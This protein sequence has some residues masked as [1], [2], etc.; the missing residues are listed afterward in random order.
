[1]KQV[2]YDDPAKRGLF[3]RRAVGSKVPAH[4][5]VWTKDG[6]RRMVVRWDTGT[7]E[8]WMTVPLTPAT[9]CMPPATGS[10]S[11]KVLISSSGIVLGSQL[12][13]K[14]MEAAKNDG[15]GRE[16]R[17]VLLAVQF[18]SCKGKLRVRV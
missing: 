15:A 16:L 5:S 7:G 1:M 11:D 9:Q 6:M 10:D 12:E 14:E 2:K 4:V 17:G 3:S 8:F 13:L 18:A